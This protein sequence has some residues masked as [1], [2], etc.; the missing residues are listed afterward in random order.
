MLLPWQAG[1][2]IL[3]ANPGYKSGEYGAAL[4]YESASRR[5]QS[6]FFVPHGYIDLHVVRVRNGS[7]GLACY[8]RKLKLKYLLALRVSLSRGARNQSCLKIS[9]SK[10]VRPSSKLDGMQAKV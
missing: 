8:R 3:V 2:G 1:W 5:C 6:R 9:Q 7:I 4:T 10:V